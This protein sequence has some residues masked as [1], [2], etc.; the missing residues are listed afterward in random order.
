[1]EGELG[2]SEEGGADRVRPTLALRSVSKRFPGQ[3]ALDRVDLD[4]HAG[5]VRGLVGQNGSGKSTLIKILSGYHD[6]EPGAEARFD[7]ESFPLGSAI[8]A[9][10]AGIR[11][12]HQDLGLVPTLSTVDNLALGHGYDGR[13]FLRLRREAKRAR[14]MLE[15]FEFRFDVHAPVTQLRAVERTGVALVRALG[16]YD[17]RPALRVLVLDEPTESLGPGE[18]ERL[19][20]TISQAARTGVAVLY[21]S[22]RLDEVLTITDEVTTLRDGRV[23]ATRPTHGLS[24]DELIR[25]II[26]TDPPPLAT[27]RRDRA[28]EVRLE[29]ENLSGGRVRKV[30]FRVRGGEILGLAGIL[31]SGREDLA[32]TIGGARANV[33]GVLRVDGSRV[34]N[35]APRDLLRAGVVFIPSDRQAESAVPSMTIRENLTLPRLEPRGPL[36]WIS[37]RRERRDARTWIERLGVQVRDPERPLIT[38]SGGNQQKVVLARALRCNP[39][40]LVVDEPVQGVDVGAKLAIY[41]LLREAAR[42]NVAVV[43]ASADAE[44]LAQFCDRVLVLREGSVAA[45]LEG[46]ECTPNQITAATF[47]TP[48]RGQ[49]GEAT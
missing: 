3:L 21:V 30:S 1:M 19:F 23:I 6:P 4:L 42:D 12:I 11:F 46:E 29:A 17:G 48:S 8:A 25:L 34:R 38:L 10:R 49:T 44:D 22:H 14:K 27:T 13:L 45:I 20:E 41:Q 31:G 36:R 15:A 16:G 7:G 2:M 5:K 24:H 43:L 35:L 40:V 9:E 33:G 18:V 26:G 39:R 37:Y 32:Y 47:A 28:A